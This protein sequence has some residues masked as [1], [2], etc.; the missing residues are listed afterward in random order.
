[1][2]S[3]QGGGWLFRWDATKF[4]EY[5]TFGM[6]INNSTSTHLTSSEFECQLNQP[7]YVPLDINKGSFY[8]VNFTLTL[9][10]PD[11]LKNSIFEMPIITQTLNIND[12]RTTN[13]KVYQPAYH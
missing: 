2:S 12:L 10:G 4:V 1:M 7:L 3:D 11:K 8:N 6:F 9:S 5:Q 13:K